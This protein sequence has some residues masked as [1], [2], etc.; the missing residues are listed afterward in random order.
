V[1]DSKLRL[2]N[3][4]LSDHPVDVGFRTEAAILSKLGRRGYSVLVPWGVN[5]RYDLVLELEGKFVRAQCKTGRL[6]D[7]TIEFNTISV[8]C[9]MNRALSR[10]YR[11]DVDVFLVH[12]P[13][14]PGDVY[15][16]PVDE[17]GLSKTRLRLE[18]TLNGQ[19]QRIRWADDYKLPA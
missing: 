5:Q 12:C 13:D 4:K 19:F 3:P 17:T 2:P 9:N 14:R 8:Q 16:M 15:C 7:G 1:T 10:D 18:P 6:R 11:G